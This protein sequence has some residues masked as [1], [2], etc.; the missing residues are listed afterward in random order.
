MVESG[1]TEHAVPFADVALAR[2]AVHDEKAVQGFPVVRTRLI[3]GDG[4]QFANETRRLIHFYQAAG[5][6]LRQCH[7]GMHSWIEPNPIVLA[8]HTNK[9]PRY[10]L[11]QVL[12]CLVG[13]LCVE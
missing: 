12:H 4:A 1:H 6:I 5:S 7:V 10:L 13:N 3:D 2:F 11:V 8:P 9:E